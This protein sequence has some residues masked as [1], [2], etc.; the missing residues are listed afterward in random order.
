MRIVQKMPVVS[1]AV[2]YANDPDIRRIDPV[3]YEIIP[4]DAAADALPLIAGHMLETLGQ[5][6]QPEASGS[7]FRNEAQRPIRIGARDPEADLSD[8]R[9]GRRRDDDL[10]E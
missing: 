2:D 5:I 6:R 9:F 7:K 1:G 10:H 8:I 3:E 4:M